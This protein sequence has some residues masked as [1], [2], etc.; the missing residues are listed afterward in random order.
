MNCKEFRDHL[1]DL[2]AGE[3][4]DAR[5][6]E[7]LGA[8]SACAAELDSLRKTMALLDE[9]KAP[10]DTSPYFYTRLR[11]RMREE[12]PAAGWLGWLRKPALALTMAGLVIISIGLFQG[13]RDLNT[14]T[15][16]EVTRVAAR[17][18]TA[19]GDLQDL[20]KNHD[21]LANFE[22]LDVLDNQSR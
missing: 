5:L 3:P 12:A 1:L 15:T 8:C 21:L 10:A 13:G 9:W 6:R 19:V 17:P 2:A 22:L 18:G 4:G 16:S 20:D 14:G 7:H 11:A